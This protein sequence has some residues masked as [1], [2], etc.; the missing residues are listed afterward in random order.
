[1]SSMLCVGFHTVLKQ[2]ALFS[3]VAHVP[4]G[5]LLPRCGDLIM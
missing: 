5:A 2:A 3:L 1:M 4:W